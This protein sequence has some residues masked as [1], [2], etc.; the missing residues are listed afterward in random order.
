MCCQIWFQLP[1]KLKSL[2]VLSK[3]VHPVITLLHKQPLWDVSDRT[4]ELTSDFVKTGQHEHPVLIQ[5]TSLCFPKMSPCPSI[6]EDAREQQQKAGKNFIWKEHH[7]KRCADQSAPECWI[8]LSVLLPGLS[9]RPALPGSEEYKD[10]FN[11]HH[12]PRFP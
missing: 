8:N 4:P 9:D 11:L 5:S 10:K 2:L 12:P 7:C 1:W 6:T 3:R